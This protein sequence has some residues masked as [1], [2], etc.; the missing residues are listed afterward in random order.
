MSMLIVKRRLL[1]LVLLAAVSVAVLAGC[2]DAPSIDRINSGGAALPSGPSAP[3][4]LACDHIS[5]ML[6]VTPL[7]VVAGETVTV[8][9]TPAHC[10][11]TDVWAGEVIVRL[12]NGDTPTGS[13]I[14]VDSTLPVT[15]TIPA[16]LAGDGYLMLVP[17]Q[18]CGD[19]TRAADCHYPFAEITIES[20]SS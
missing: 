3:N 9:T 2:A 12:G 8:T 4:D 7:D 10:P 20:Q 16:T 18:D 15:V 17:D 1:E 11:V 5:L 6:N 19:V 13:R 14:E